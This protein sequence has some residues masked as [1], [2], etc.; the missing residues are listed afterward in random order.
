MRK[1]IIYRILSYLAVEGTTNNKRVSETQQKLEPRTL[2]DVEEEKEETRW[3]H[4]SPPRQRHRGRVSER[5]REWRWRLV[6]WA[7]HE[8]GLG[9]VLVGTDGLHH[10][11]D[12]SNIG[13]VGGI[14]DA[15]AASEKAANTTSTIDDGRARVARIGGGAGLAVI[16]QDGP[17]HRILGLLL[18]EMV[19][20]V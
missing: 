4:L 2:S 14:G 19:A 9:E 16:G 17:L 10:E 18:T 6:F 5:G 12:R 3:I 7:G 15:A 13:D 20:R 1:Y 8:E 11:A